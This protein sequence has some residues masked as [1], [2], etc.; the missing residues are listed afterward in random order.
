MPRAARN[1]I[2]E[3]GSLSAGAHLLSGK[4]LK[5]GSVTTKD[6]STP[7]TDSDPQA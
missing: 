1:H 7:E 5:T 2:G 6:G 3:D 4:N